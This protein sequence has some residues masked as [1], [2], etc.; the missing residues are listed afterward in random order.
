MKYNNF[1]LTYYTFYSIM[2]LKIKR[3]DKANATAL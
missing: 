1:L 2:V 3:T